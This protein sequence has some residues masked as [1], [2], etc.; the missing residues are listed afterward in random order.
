MV[1]VLE[2]RSHLRARRLQRAAIPRSL[3][4]VPERRSRLVD[5]QLRFLQPSSRLQPLARELEEM[6]L[7]QLRIGA[8]AEARSTMGQLPALAPLLARS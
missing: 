8:S 4:V 5:R 6:W 2:H 7:V 3:Q 1:E